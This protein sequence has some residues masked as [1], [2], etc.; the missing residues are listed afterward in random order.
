MAG[1]RKESVNSSQQG[2]QE[3]WT[4]ATFIV[5][6]GHLEKLRALAYWDRKQFKEVID[7]ALIS[8]LG[9]RR[10]KAVGRK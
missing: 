3:G 6:K 7:E 2:L 4:R 8:Y 10:I 1:G 5:R 9:R